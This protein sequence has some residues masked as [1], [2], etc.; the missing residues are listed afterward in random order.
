VVEEDLD[1]EHLGE[2]Q[3]G[4]VEIVVAV[5]SV[6]A[7]EAEASVLEEVEDSVVAEEVVVLHREVLLVVDS[8]VAEEDRRIFR[9]KVSRRSGHNGVVGFLSVDGT[10]DSLCMKMVT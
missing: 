8:A 2:E 6:A 1:V 9:C 7:E 10:E 5:D 4:E 3:E